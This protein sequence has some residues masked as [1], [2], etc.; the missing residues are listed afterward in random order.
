V[1]SYSDLGADKRE[2][3]NH[4]SRFSA[5][6]FLSGCSFVG[7]LGSIEEEKRAQAILMMEA[8]VWQKRQEQRI[9]EIA[10][11]L[12]RSAE[13]VEPL[14]LPLLLARMKDSCDST[15]I[16]SEPGPTAKPSGSAAV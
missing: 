10:A 3:R 14:S 5:A 7:P 2:G 16:R 4:D 8:Q 9:L 6:D 11:R 12:I 13:T 15:P 1:L